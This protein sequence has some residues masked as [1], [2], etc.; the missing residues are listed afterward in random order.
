MVTV[1]KEEKHQEHLEPLLSKFGAQPVIARLGGGPNESIGVFIDGELVGQLTKKMTERHTSTLW[2]A[3]E[4]GFTCTCFA[5]LERDDK[6][7]IQVKLSL[8]NLPDSTGHARS[9][10]IRQRRARSPQATA[11]RRTR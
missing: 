10:D 1:T 11:A 4:A 5:F 6:G 3:H 8:L 2:A 7:I 9:V